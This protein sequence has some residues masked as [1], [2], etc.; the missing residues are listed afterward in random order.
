VHKPE[1]RTVELTEVTNKISSLVN[2]VH[3]HDTRVLVE[4][5][6][7]PIAA[8]ISFED[9]KRFAELERQRKEQFSVID[10]VRAAFADVSAEEIEAE[11][12]RI[13]ARDRTGTQPDCKT[14][15]QQ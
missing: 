8:I 4:Q 1:N 14:P 11:T 7:T 2:E 9:L 12:D 3:L 6:G 15:I 10:R 13:F 5:G